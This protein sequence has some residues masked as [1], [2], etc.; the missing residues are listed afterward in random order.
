M[1]FGLYHFKHFEGIWCG[2]YLP[3]YKKESLLVDLPQSVCSMDQKAL[4]K[5]LTLQDVS[6]Y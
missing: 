3:E 6:L 1:N 5:S 2:L 4:I